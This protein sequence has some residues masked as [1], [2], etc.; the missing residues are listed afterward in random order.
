ML[1]LIVKKYK[2]ENI[3]D[4]LYLNFLLETNYYY[5]LS[6]QEIE[7]FSE[8]ILKFNFNDI[9]YLYNIFYLKI[10][11]KK[12]FLNQEDFKKEVVKLNLTNKELSIF[13]VLLKELVNKIKDFQ[14]SYLNSDSYLNSS[15]II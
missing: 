6:K 11:L 14:F 13:N 1:D 12:Y 7:N 10:D 3:V 2:I 15:I 4:I 8:K 9:S 5:F